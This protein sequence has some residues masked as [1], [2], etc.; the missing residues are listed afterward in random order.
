MR[1]P[2]AHLAAAIG[3]TGIVGAVVFSAPPARPVGPRTPVLVEL[4]TSEGCSSC[5][6][7]DALLTRLIT[8]QPIDGVEVV[9]LSLHVDYWNRL[10]WVDPFSKS[11]FTNRQ[12]DYATIWGVSR[13]YRPQAVVDGAREFVG[14]DEAAAREFIRA[15]A[16]VKDAGGAGRRDPRRDGSAWGVRID[17]GPSSARASKLDVL[18]AVAEDG[19]VS[20]VRRGENADRRLSHIAVV[21]VLERVAKV[22]LS[23]GLTTTAAAAGPDVASRQDSAGR[24]R[25][26]P[27]NAWGDRRRAGADRLDLKSRLKNGRSGTAR[28]LRTAGARSGVLERRARHGDKLP[29]IAT[30]AQRQL[31]HAVARVVAHLAVRGD[32]PELVHPAPT[33]PDDEL[34][35]PS[36]VRPSLGHPAARTARTGGRARSSRHRRPPCTGS[37]TAPASSSPACADPS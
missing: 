14:S 3:L 17:I 13:I 8:T 24:V 2:L 12:N 16:A 6:P 11:A 23:K 36:G 5:P 21:R 20:D 32:P 37:T 31:Q 1:L 26:G 19:V 18:L 25:A 4:F 9:G 7:A 22:D 27:R 35:D 34:S 29:R 33:G 15:A 10:G 30:R 28:P